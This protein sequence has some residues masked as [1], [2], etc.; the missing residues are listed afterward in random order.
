[1]RTMLAIACVAVGA[2]ALHGNGAARAEN[3]RVNVQVFHPSAHVGDLLTTMG[4]DIGPP[5]QWSAS[6]YANFGKNALVFIDATD[7]GT[8]RDEV[9]Q[10]QLTLDLGGSLAL[11]NRLSLGLTIPLHVLNAGQT[12]GFI[13]LSPNP[14]SFA[15]GDIRLSPKVGILM[16]EKHANGLG[17]AASLDLTVPSGDGDSFVSDPFTIAPVVIADFKLGEL[18]LA[19]NL[20]FRIRTAESDLY[21]YATASHELFWHLG[22]RYG[23]VPGQLDVIG[24]I[25]GASADF[26]TANATHLEGVL[27]GR[28]KLPDFGLAFTLG[29]GSGFTKG[30]GNTKFRVFAGVEFAPEVVLDKDKDGILDE[31]DKCPEDPEDKDN[32]QDQDGCPDPDNDNDKVL[33]PSDK[34]PLD[35]EDID[36]FQDE[37]GCPDLD[38]DGDGKNDPDD[39][40]PNEAED[41]DAFKDDDGC[42][43][44]DNDE[45]KIL[46]GVDKC[47][48]EAEVYNGKDDEDGCPDETLAAI[49]QGKIVIKDKIY[50]D[51][52]KATIK[53]QSDPV[54][55]AVQGILKA[56]PHVKKV[57]IEGH[58]D[59]VGNATRNKKLSDDRAKS[60][61]AWLIAHG[62]DAERLS[63]VGYGY[64][65]PSVLAKTKEAREANRR[66]EFII[67]E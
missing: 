26:S 46:D 24:E 65:R 60:V 62:I 33:D 29:G 15:F 59:D 13:P 63:A 39:Q 43:E 49:E 51:T 19:A 45:D 47:P 27:A 14:A 6:L 21:G 54:L 36:T 38:N 58:T 30:Y 20:G 57:S 8:F 34:C 53:P 31:T 11:F 61:M 55:N 25:Y 35:P 16:R 4:T 64:E 37:D 22:G 7:E 52:N 17:L 42:P 41:V 3:P 23:V 40:C 50:F 66:V 5:L 48:N 10:D 12:G 32:F 44:A 28:L 9:I 2:L 56:N 18:T 67:Q 1:M